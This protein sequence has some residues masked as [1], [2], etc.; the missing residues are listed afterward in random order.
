MPGASGWAGTVRGDQLTWD[1]QVH[2]MPN[3][4]EPDDEIRPGGDAL[5][6]CN[7]RHGICRVARV[8][9]KGWSARLWM[10]L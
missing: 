7:L 4:T 9:E 8:D 6:V 10:V 3:E 5:C 2:A 1:V